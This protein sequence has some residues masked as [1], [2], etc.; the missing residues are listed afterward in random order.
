MYE[1]VIRKLYPYGTVR[2]V[3]FGPVRGRKYIVEKGMG[4][5]YAL[6]LEAVAPRLFRKFIRDGM[7]VYDVGANKG[8]SALYFAALIGKAGLVVAFEPASAEFARLKQN[9]ELNQLDM[10]KPIM[11]AAA[12]KNGKMR[13]QYAPSHP[14]QG[15]LSDVEPTYSVGGAAEVEVEARTLDS[16]LGT[17]PPP[18]FIKI[19]VEGAAGSVLRGAEKILSDHRPIVYLELH[20][21]DEQAAVSNLLS[22]FAYKAETVA[23]NAVPDPEAGWFSP[24]VCRPAETQP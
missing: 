7:T 17:T 21:R 15:K 1:A 24:L 4:F 2:S 16:L 12:D 3:L 9:I 23:G 8:Q 5:T 11:A 13:F 20:G 19:D 14:T 6:G 22:K 10:V 18:D